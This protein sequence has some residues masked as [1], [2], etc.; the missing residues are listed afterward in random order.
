MFAA[1]ASAT[2]NGTG[3]D[4]RSLQVLMMMGVNSSTTVSLR[5]SAD[6]V[7]V[8]TIVRTRNLNW[9]FEYLIILRE[10]HSK[11]P[12]S[13]RPATSII[14]PTRSRMMSMLMAAMAS[15]GPTTPNRTMSPAPRSAAAGRSMC[16]RGSLLMEMSA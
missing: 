9:F 14:M 10:T 12:H 3:L 7:P 16:T 4:F 5:T 6:R 15:C 1:M 2:R 11:N 8:T 13:S